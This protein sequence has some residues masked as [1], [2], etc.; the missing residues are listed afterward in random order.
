MDPVLAN[1]SKT[2]VPTV[3]QLAAI[4]T[5]PMPAFV[6]EAVYMRGLFT[7]SGAYPEFIRPNPRAAFRDFELAAK[8]GYSP[9]W[10]R[11]GRDYESFDDFALAIDCFGRGVKSG[12]E[13]CAYVSFLAFPKVFY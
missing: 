1:L 4:N 13:S 10:F 5:E 3:L 9:A 12:V 7:S 8:G 6:A 11:L 2:A